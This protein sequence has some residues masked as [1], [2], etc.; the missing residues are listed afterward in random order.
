MAQL[1]RHGFHIVSAALV[2]QQH[3]GGHILQRG[4]AESAAALALADFAVQ[5]VLFKDAAGQGFYFGIKLVVSIQHQFGSLTKGVLFFSLGN[6]SINIIA[7]QPLN[8]QQTRFEAEEALEEGDVLAGHFQQGIHH[9]IGDVVAQVAGRDGLGMV[10]QLH[11]LTA[12]IAH[13]VLVDLPQQGGVV[14]I[15]LI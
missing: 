15:D 2:V 4:G 13:H 6:R 10:A 5:V 11:V 3:P 8:A 9:G 12:P 7:A 1:V 14:A